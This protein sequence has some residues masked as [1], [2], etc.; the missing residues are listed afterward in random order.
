M[1]ARHPFHA[2]S[3]LGPAPT[4]AISG[5]EQVDWFTRVKAYWQRPNHKIRDVARALLTHIGSDDGRCFPSLATLAKSAGCKVKTVQRAI[6]E[7][8]RVGFLGK[9]L[10]R[11]L[12]GQ[13]SNAYLILD[14][15]TAAEAEKL[16]LCQPL[17]DLSYYN[18]Q[19]ASS[20]AGL[21]MDSLPPPPPGE[22][23]A[24][25]LR[26]VLGWV[27]RGVSRGGQGP[28]PPPLTAEQQIML[29]RRPGSG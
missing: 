19:E 7:L 22:T 15:D 12:F 6:A 24:G 1:I 3:V 27:T 2:G 10:R 16:D 25:A 9:I 28:Q 29:L 18:R 17:P 23:G 14:P 26:R 5:R 4:Q 13:T 21:S 20:E 8:V 11:D